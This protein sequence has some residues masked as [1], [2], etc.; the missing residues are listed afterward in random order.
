MGQHRS[1]NLSLK[2]RALQCVAQR[3]HSCAEL[4]NKLLAHAAADA[5][6]AEGAAAEVDAVLDWMQAKA[7][8]SDER[9]VE[10]RVH[11]RA[12]RFGNARIR[13]EL[14]RHGL[15]LSPELAQDLRQTEKARACEVWQRK[16]AQAPAS[17]A[18]RARQMRFLAGR[19]FSPEVIGQVLRDVERKRDHEPL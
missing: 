19:G 15:A 9:F 3:E 17:A 6:A 1:L 16:F 2:G 7:Y 12:S 11:A 4:R 5:D 13:S 8:L 14:A 18:E 10:G